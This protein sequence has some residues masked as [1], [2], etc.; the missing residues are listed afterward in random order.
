MEQLWTW[1]STPPAKGD[2]LDLFGALCLLL[3]APGYLLSAYLAGPGA[4]RLAKDPLQLG[5]IR[6]W[7]SIGLWVFGVGLFFFGVRVLQINPLWFGAPIWLV[8]SIIAVIFAAVRCL[9]WWRTV[10]PAERT[11]RLSVDSIYPVP[12]LGSRIS[13]ASARRTVPKTTVRT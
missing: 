2:V 4:D 11:R 5:G 10:Y 13:S 6:R 3:F 1:L 8:G 9:D 7:A 12:D